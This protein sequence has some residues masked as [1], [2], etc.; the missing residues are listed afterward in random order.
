VATPTESKVSTLR[1][2]LD[3]IRG[4]R[5][6]DAAATALLGSAPPPLGSFLVNLYVNSSGSEEDKTRQDR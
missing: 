2:I 6:L 4:N 5:I 3:K 1:G